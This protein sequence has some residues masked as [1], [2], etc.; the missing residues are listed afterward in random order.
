MDKIPPMIDL[1]RHLEG[2]VRLDT[3]IS[4][5][6][7]YQLPLPAWTVE[8]LQSYV[9][10]Q[11][12]TSDI[13]LLLPKFDI[14]RQVFVNETACRQ[15]TIECLQDAE[16]QGL[17]Y[18]ELRF[19]PLFMAELHKLDPFSVTAA[20]CEGWQEFSRNSKMR[21]TLLV[22]LSRTYGA[23]A[24]SIE[25]ECGLRYRNSGI[26]GVDLAG[27]EAR[28]PAGEFKAL[29]NTARNAGLK[30]TA[31]AGEFAGAD[32]VRETI[33]TLSPDRLGHAVHAADDPRVMDVI[34]Q[35]GIAVECCPTSN[36]LTT[37]V[38]RMEDH[39]LPLFLR[40]GILA[41][42]NT[43]DPSLMGNL[44]LLDEYQNAQNVIGCTEDEVNQARQN[45]ALVT[46]S[47]QK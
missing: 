16:D 10:I 34:F 18:L 8:A 29:F 42:I 17:D 38:S 37:A 21:S 25:L 14:L 36:V 22:I 15:V 5:S 19:S 9:W 30:I 1:H 4:I 20:V 46:F 26:S 33:E 31:H 45:A 6:R 13:L 28:H 24:C 27:D 40:H 47:D 23:E 7:Q 11:K 43:D 3:V 2:A 35:K 41:T 39:P 12:P 44:T 32:S